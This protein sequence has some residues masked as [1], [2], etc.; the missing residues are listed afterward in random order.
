[1]KE[2]VDDARSAYLLPLPG[3]HFPA[4]ATAAAGFAVSPNRGRRTAAEAGGA[5]DA[6]DTRTAVA[7]GSAAA[8]EALKAPGPFC[9]CVVPT[10]CF[11]RKR[12][13]GFGIRVRAAVGAGASSSGSVSLSM[14]LGF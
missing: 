8:A 6:C 12:G 7:A 5:V 9:G 11:W 2:S 14:A 1:M 3:P 13:W 4:T 10:A